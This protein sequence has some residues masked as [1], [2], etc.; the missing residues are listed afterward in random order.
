MRGLKPKDALRC[1]RCGEGFHYFCYSLP[2]G[3]FPNRLQELN[4]PIR[5]LLG[6]MARYGDTRRPDFRCPR[7]K[8]K[9]VM[10]RAP[11]R[12]SI[13]DSWL[14]LCSVRAQ[15]D[16]M[17]SE[18]S[19]YATSCMYALRRATRFGDEYDIP[20]M[21]AHGPEE[22]V[23]MNKQFGAVGHEQIRWWL[24][25]RTR[26]VGW[27]TSKKE[28]SALFNYYRAMGWDLDHIPTSTPNFT[29]FMNGMLQWKGASTTQC[30]IFRDVLIE[31]MCALIRG[32]FKRARGAQKLHLARVQL[33]WHAYMQTGAR[34][35]EL[36]EQKLGPMVDSFCFGEEAR[37]KRIRPHL[38]FDATLQTKENRFSATSLW[39]CATTM[40]D[41]LASGP[42][43][44]LLV[45]QLTNNGITDRES[46]VFADTDGTRWQMGTFWRREVLPRLERLQAERLGGLEKVDLTLFGSNSFRRSWTTLASSHRGGGVVDEHLRDRQG[47]WRTKSRT[48]CLGKMVNVY[49]DAQPEDLLLATYWL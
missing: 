49:N 19:S 18:S 20:V 28:R 4:K 25:D 33:A 35:N 26:S 30:A 8:F 44:V 15:L 29:S 42:C 2:T 12:G 16:E 37:R 48:R 7:C 1:C 23:R 45:Q 21:V 32:E 27:D 3:L 22:L 13:K 14:I 40:R 43:A 41:L 6:D 46:L 31:D 5:H 38:R 10:R 9:S 11:V 39:C 47:R 34:A 24:A 36:F 17:L